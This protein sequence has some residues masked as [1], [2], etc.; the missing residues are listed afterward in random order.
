MQPKWLTVFL[1]KYGKKKY[2]FS[3]NTNA[4]LKI[5]IMAVE[6]GEVLNSS[7]GGGGGGVRKN[8]CPRAE[9]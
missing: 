7:R 4:L 1:A 5:Q 9:Q 6:F 2:H 8:S 3:Y